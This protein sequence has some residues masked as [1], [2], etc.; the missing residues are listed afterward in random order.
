MEISGQ[1]VGAILEFLRRTESVRIL[2]RLP[3]E[4]KTFTV[5][6]N[7]FSEDAAVFNFHEVDGRV[8]VEPSGQNTKF[9][10]AGCFI[11]TFFH[12]IRTNLLADGMAL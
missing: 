1:R 6:I 10:I 2:S 9:E 5:T 4:N 3:A 12:L 7:E 11:P 8:F